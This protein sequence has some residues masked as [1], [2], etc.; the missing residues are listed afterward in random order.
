MKLALTLLGSSLFLV[1]SLMFIPGLNFVHAV[2]SDPFTFSE[3]SSPY[4]IPYKNWT[5]KWAAW[6][7]ST[8]RSQHW[9]YENVPGVDHKAEDCS[10]RQDP[11]SPVFF[12]PWVGIERGTTATATC[13]VPQDK[14]IFLS[15][16]GGISDYSDPSVKIKTPAELLRIVTEGN[17]YPNKYE[18]TLNG[19]PLHLINDET[20][21]VT[22]DLFN[23]TLPKDNIWE[24]PEGPDKGITQ[25]WWIML[26]PL[27][28]GEHTLHYTTGYSDSRSDPSIPPGQGNLAPYIQD[29]TYHLIVK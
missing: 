15:V 14:A 28:P 2:G 12:L 3:N 23:F 7:A 26:K 21:K 1:L 13:I 27:P 25:G 24:E 20:H 6:H 11:A 9:N 5:A 16:N 4:D 19:K 18:A 10:F 22:S 17:V 29:V 8:P